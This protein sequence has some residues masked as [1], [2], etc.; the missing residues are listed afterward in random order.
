MALGKKKQF[1][2]I[3]GAETNHSYI[4][5]KG[6]TKEEVTKKFLDYTNGTGTIRDIKEVFTLE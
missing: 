6:K 3:Y 4:I 5:V 2:I 1:L